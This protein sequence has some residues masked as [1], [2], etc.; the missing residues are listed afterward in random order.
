MLSLTVSIKKTNEMKQLKNTYLLILGTLFLLS[1]SKTESDF[2]A[3]TQE[4]ITISSSTI[5]ASTADS[6]TFT[7]L[8]SINSNNVTAESKIFVNGSLI[9]GNKFTF[10]AAGSFGVYATKGNLTSNVITVNVTAVAPK[11]YKHHVL[12][13]EYSGTW[14]GNCPRILYA[15]DLLKQQTDK[16]IVVSTHLLN[17]DPFISTD[18][19]SLAAQQGV[20]GVPNGFINRNITWTGPQDQN[21]SQV[22]NAIQASS[23]TGIAI[24]SSTTGSNL[25]VNIKIGYTNPLT[26]TAKLTAYLVED[27]LFS[28]QTNY[29]STL[30][31]GQA[32]IPNFEYSGVLRKVI[33][34]LSGDAIP[35]SGVS[36]AKD[37]T[38]AIPSNISNI[39]NAKIV[40]LVTNA[41]GTVL[42]ALEAKVGENKMFEVL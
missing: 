11:N 10:L 38:F 24:N 8:S 27:K 7:V 16:A 39:A 28:S 2:T 32:T 3:T 6:V 20:S 40:V 21:V 30:Y 19:N 37:Y 42:N 29:S 26:G 9:T 33:S 15:V 34:S 18:G 31:G 13:E 23:E 5:N 14:C 41:S 35:T 25:T 22:I 4:T 1:C 36:N 17:G 12:V